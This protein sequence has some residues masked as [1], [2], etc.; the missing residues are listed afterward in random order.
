MSRLALQADLPEV[1]Q[2][3][4]VEEVMVVKIVVLEKDIVAKAKAKMEIA[5]CQS[6]KIFYA[7]AAKKQDI[8][9][10]TI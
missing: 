4:K 1:V 6:T 9:L 5:A 7:I 8:L 10:I 2:K 3:L